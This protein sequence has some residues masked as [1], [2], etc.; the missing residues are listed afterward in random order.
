MNRAIQGHV[1]ARDAVLGLNRVMN[2]CRS[3]DRVATALAS[4]LDNLG[5]RRCFLAVYESVGSEIPVTGERARLILD[6]RDGK[7]TPVDDEVFPTHQLLPEP[8]RTELQQGMI[9]LQPL[10]GLDRD[11]GYVL[12][13]QVR[14]VTRV[15]EAL[16]HD[17]SRTLD[18]VASTQSLED[19]A[20]TLE[21]L[22]AQRTQEL[23]RANA[24]LQRS[25]MVDG[26]TR[27]ANRI[28]FERHLEAQWKELD[29]RELALLILDVDLFKA[30]NDRY[31]HVHGDEALKI[32]ASC[33]QESARHPGDLATR[34]GGEEFAVVL[35]DSGVEAA[36]AVA[37]RFRA[38]LAEA[39]IPH[40]ASSVAP[41]VTASIGIAV[42]R[43]RPGLSLAV[44]VNAADQALYRAKA[45]GRNRIAFADRI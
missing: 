6:Y 39:A 38:L 24:E 31:G 28:A 13:E 5:I 16:R 23:K 20:A 27:I 19:H 29:G 45:L 43:V 42:A 4:R 44:V 12:Y 26:L 9:V 1:A 36:S 18:S 11:L 32:V 10:S 21:A 37:T 2:R 40:S 30:Y 25:L 22:V 35:P 15:A 3:M 41:V 8:L 33:L 17:L 7:T 34:Y 14:G